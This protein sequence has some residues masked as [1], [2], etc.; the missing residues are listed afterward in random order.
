MRLSTVANRF[1]GLFVLSSW[2]EASRSQD[3]IISVQWPFRAGETPGEAGKAVDQAMN[4]NGR[5]SPHGAVFG[6]LSR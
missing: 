1:C 2:S 5:V 4:R 6:R 3:A